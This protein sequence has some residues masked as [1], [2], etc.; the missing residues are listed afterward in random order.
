MPSIKD[1]AIILNY[2]LLQDRH[3]VL[4]CF[5]KEHGIVRGLWV[6]QKN[7]IAEGSEVGVSWHARLAEQLGRFTMDSEKIPYTIILSPLK[8]SFLNLALEIICCTF[9]L[10]APQPT[11]WQ[12]LVSYKTLLNDCAV[13]ANRHLS[14]CRHLSLYLEFEALLLEISGFSTRVRISK[15]APNISTASG[16]VG[17][18]FDLAQNNEKFLYD[19][20]LP[21][22]TIPELRRYLVSKIAAVN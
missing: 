18:M 2:R 13:D 6:Q 12:S 3:Y 22:K 10:H 20:L 17:E 1:D 11:L 19:C 21:Y 4:T 9:P 5:L 14:F 16:D 8:S 7:H 15:S